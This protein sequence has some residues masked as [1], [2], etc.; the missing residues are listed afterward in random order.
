MLLKNC[1]MEK[2][3]EEE[4]QIREDCIASHC[5][6]TGFGKSLIYAVFQLFMTQRGRRDKCKL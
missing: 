5:R 3:F 4:K 1:K 2:V 6:G